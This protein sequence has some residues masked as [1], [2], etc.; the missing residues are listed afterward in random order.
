MKPEEVSLK[1]VKQN[2]TKIDNYAR[3]TVSK[4]KER[5]QLSETSATND[6]QGT[7]S[8]KTQTSVSLLKKG[9]DRLYMDVMDVNPEFADDILLETLLTT[10]VENLHAVSH[11][12][13]ETFTVLQYAQDFGKIV[14]E[15][16]KRTS[17]WAAKYYT[18]DRS[19][20]PV[21]QS[22]VPLLAVAT[23]ALLPSEGITPGMEEQIKEWLESYRPVVC[24]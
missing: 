17:R 16:I 24:M 21:P 14:K 22:A 19:Y 1:Q 11:F 3:V 18:H 15:S 20:Y 8:Q 7:V 23:M 10:Q 4:V 2:V 5:Y 6:P 13:H 12:K 9:S